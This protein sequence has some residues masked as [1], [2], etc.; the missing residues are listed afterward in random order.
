MPD[1]AWASADSLAVLGSRTAGTVEVLMLDAATGAITAEGAPG[2]P[3]E[4]AAA[5]GLPTL[6]G[7][8]NGLIYS[9]SAGAWREQVRAASPTYPG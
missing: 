6:V 4:I 8:S 3:I 7:S 5:P 9:F 2:E 1:V